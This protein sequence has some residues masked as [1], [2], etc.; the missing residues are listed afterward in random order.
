MRFPTINFLLFPPLCFSILLFFPF[1]EIPFFP[2]YDT[3]YFQA[4]LFDRYFPKGCTI[5]SEA[6]SRSFIYK[7]LTASL[8]GI[9]SS[10]DAIPLE[11]FDRIY[12][13]TTMSPPASKFLVT[14]S[15]LMKKVLLALD[16][17]YV[18]NPIS[19]IILLL[20]IRFD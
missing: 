7:L 11:D 1:P 19:S 6:D 17:Q 3:F 13:L 18:T 16:I 12:G 14:F 10:K 15:I 5:E 8:S 2:R 4:A 20:T 9:I